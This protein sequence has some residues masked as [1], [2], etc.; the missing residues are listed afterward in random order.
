MSAKNNM[1]MVLDELMNDCYCL[2]CGDILDGHTWNKGN[3]LAKPTFIK[4]QFC[5]F[6]CEREYEKLFGNNRSF[7][8]R[9]T[10]IY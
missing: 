5:H 3:L 6:T 7:Y 2:S 9:K 8:D 10:K 4:L 1:N